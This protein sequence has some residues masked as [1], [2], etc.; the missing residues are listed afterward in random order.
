MRQQ[1]DSFND[2]INTSLQEIVD[3]NNLITVIPQSQHVPGV[4]VENDVEKKYE[5]RCGKHGYVP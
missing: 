4:Q 5:V 3:E 1:L 2:F